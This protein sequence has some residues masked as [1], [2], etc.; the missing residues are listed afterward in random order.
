MKR[1][2]TDTQV[3]NAGDAPNA[4]VSPDN[5]VRAEVGS[6]TFTGR[7]LGS[8]YDGEPVVY[9]ED[10]AGRERAV[11]F[12]RETHAVEPAGGETI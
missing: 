7:V 12:Q 3:N 4:P 8:G 10:T 1:Y 11:R 2:G 6:A 9:I 5:R